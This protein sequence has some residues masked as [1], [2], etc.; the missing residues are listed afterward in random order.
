MTT[1]LG[2]D[3]EEKS[4]HRFCHPVLN[5][6]GRLNNSLWIPDKG[7]PIFLP[8]R[9]GEGPNEHKMPFTQHVIAFQKRQG[10]FQEAQ[11]NPNR[12]L[13]GLEDKDDRPRHQRRLSEEKETGFQ[14]RMLLRQK[15][16]IVPIGLHAHFHA[17]GQAKQALGLRNV[18]LSIIMFP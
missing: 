5:G 10:V 15:D 6:R 3:K 9:S 13:G 18:Y 17:R 7:K 16:G 11:A 2:T 14:V 12:P 4:Q 1:E 8:S